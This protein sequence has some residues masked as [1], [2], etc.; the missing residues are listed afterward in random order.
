M[1]N[2]LIEQ[3]FQLHFEVDII[4]LKLDFETSEEMDKLI[5]QHIEIDF[6]IVLV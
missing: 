3:Q 4:L 5:Q 1:K 6:I 2:I